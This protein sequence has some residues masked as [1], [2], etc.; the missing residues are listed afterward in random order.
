M[1]GSYNKDGRRNDSKKIVLNTENFILK[2]Q[3]ENQEIDGRMWFRGMTTTA[4]AKRM[5]EKSCK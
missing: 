3:W 4:G 1:G 2:D 5:E